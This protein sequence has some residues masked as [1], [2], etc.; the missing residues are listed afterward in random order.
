[1][2][3]IQYDPNRT[4]FIALLIYADGE[5]LYPCPTRI[6]GWRKSGKRCDVAPEVGNALPM[7]NMPLGTNV[8]NIEMQPGQGGVENW[9][10]VQ[11]HLHS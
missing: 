2:E 10:A 1:M 9:P 5:A 3:S 7:K 4:A 8:H 11:D 6:T